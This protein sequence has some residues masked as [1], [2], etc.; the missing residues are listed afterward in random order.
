MRSNSSA[1]SKKPHKRRHSDCPA[2]SAE[3]PQ[4]P[5]AST[6]GVQLSAGRYDYVH[7]GGLG[8]LSDGVRRALGRPPRDFSEYAKAAAAQGLWNP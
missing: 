4:E 7:A 3:C 1:T 2:P 6:E 5:D 8:S